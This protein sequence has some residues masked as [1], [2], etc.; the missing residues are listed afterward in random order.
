M[1]RWTEG[2]TDGRKDGRTDGQ[3]ERS[4]IFIF[5]EV[6][7]K[8]LLAIGGTKVVFMKVAQMSLFKYRWDKCHVFS[9]G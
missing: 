1:D 2:R 8:S 5:M 3:T 6:A 4:E 7:L 9:Y